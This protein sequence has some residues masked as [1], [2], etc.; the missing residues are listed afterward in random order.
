MFLKPVDQ[1]HLREMSGLT[2]INIFKQLK[3]FDFDSQID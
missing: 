2:L 1:N 3:M